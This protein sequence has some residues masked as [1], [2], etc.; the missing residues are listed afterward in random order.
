ME[1]FTIISKTFDG[2]GLEVEYSPEAGANNAWF[3]DNNVKLSDDEVD[4]LRANES[5]NEEL[6]AAWALA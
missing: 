6:C 1:Y 4:Q 2:R 5:D 3:L